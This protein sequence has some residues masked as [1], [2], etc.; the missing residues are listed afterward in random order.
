MM[1]KSFIISLALV[2][3]TILSGAAAAAETPY[4]DVPAGHWAY[5][6]VKQLSDAGIVEGYSDGSYRGQKTVTRYEMATITAN[7][8]TKLSQ[9]DAGQKALIEKLA[10]EFSA[11]LAAHEVRL[12]ALENKVDKSVKL[13]GTVRES[14]EWDK[15][16]DSKLY[17]H[18]EFDVTAPLTDSLLF[19][20]RVT[21]ENKAGNGPVATGLGYN[22]EGSQVINVDQAFLA[23]RALGFDTFLLGRLPFAFGQGLLASSEEAGW[24]RGACDGIIIGNGNKLKYVVAAGRLGLRDY[25]DYTGIDYVDRVSSSFSLQGYMLTYS[26]N[27][28]LTLWASMMNSRERSLYESTSVA[29]NYKGIKNIEISSEYG[30]N[31]S[32]YANLN[33]D[34]D[35]AKAWFAKVKYKGADR[36]RDHSYGFWAAYRKA[37]P[38]F[39]PMGLGAAGFIRTS[40]YLKGGTSSGM[41]F[42]S[43]I[44]GYDCGFEMTVF[45]DAILSLQ[46]GDYENKKGDSKAKN[47]MTTLEY[48]F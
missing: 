13:S 9:A 48:K 6:A 36:A 32:D 42:G 7:A 34:G 35:A 47:F 21:A 28:N 3:V 11:E 5:D 22:V 20:G 8:L 19:K 12:T 45:R 25:L 33:N 27:K 41:N 44:K 38:Y 24:P 1:K 18:V 10:T 23:G 17:T 14:Y 30:Q 43:D 39:D 16:Y 4:S 26:A 2:L 15:N 29:L 46:Y 37:D 40:H 31:D